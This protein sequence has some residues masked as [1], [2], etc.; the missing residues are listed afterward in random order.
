MNLSCVEHT[1]KL[2]LTQSVVSVAPGALASVKADDV[3]KYFA[4]FD[5]VACAI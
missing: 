4:K 1:V 3:F 2:P 5:V